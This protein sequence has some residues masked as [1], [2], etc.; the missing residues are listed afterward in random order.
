MANIGVVVDIEPGHIFP[1]FCLARK[2]VARGHRVCYLV[3]PGMEDLIRSQGLEF[4]TIMQDLIPPGFLAELRT[5]SV[6]KGVPIR[7]LIEER[8]F[9]PLLQGKVFDSVL[10]E[11]KPAVIL[12]NS[13]H[14]FEAVA[15]RY[16][17]NLP[18]LLL[19]T[20]IRDDPRS[21]YCKVVTEKLF[22]VPGAAALIDLLLSAGV[23]IKSLTDVASVILGQPELVMYPKAFELPNIIQDPLVFYGGHDVDLNRVE[24]RFCWNQL[25][26]DRPLIYCSLGTQLDA[27]GEISRRFIRTAI[28]AVTPRPDWQLVVSLGSRIDPKEFEPV[29]S[30][31]LLS[32]WVPQIQMLARASVMITHAGIGTVKECIIH[33]VPMLA[34]PLMRDQFKCAERIVYHRLGLRADIQCI[35][36]EE[37][38][39]MLEH[40]IADDSCRKRVEVMKEEFQRAEA[41]NFSVSLIEKV[42]AGSFPD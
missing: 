33:G 2:L 38:S 13:L 26:P 31:V 11:I 15:I 30:H 34:A 3:M 37:L 21:E 8:Y 40:L 19:T 18:I 5:M 20:I 32:S 4:R 7:T 22:E 41:L 17:Y 35:G 9:G 28:D 6:E 27:E 14:Y 12:I 16:K 10:K 36:P 39:S 24:D 23:G 1:T 42:A 25:L 29:P